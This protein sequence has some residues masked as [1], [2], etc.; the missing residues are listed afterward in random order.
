ML[1]FPHPTIQTKLCIISLFSPFSLKI[2]KT[3]SILL[4]LILPLINDI[5]LIV[6]L[7]C[8]EYT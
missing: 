6:E 4:Y 5:V 2:T 1:T 8:L 3:I 7:Q